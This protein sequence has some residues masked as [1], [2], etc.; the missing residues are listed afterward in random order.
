MFR[1]GFTPSTQ[2]VE[3]S[4]ANAIRYINIVPWY[5]CRIHRALGAKY[6]VSKISW[7][8]FT[9]CAIILIN[10]TDCRFPLAFL[11]AFHA[12]LR[13]VSCKPVV[14]LA[15][16]DMFTV[17]FRSRVTR[18]I[19]TFRSILVCSYG[20]TTIVFISA[21]K[22]RERICRASLTLCH[23]ISVKPCI[24][25]APVYGGCALRRKGINRTLL[26]FDS[27]IFARWNGT[28]VSPWA[29]AKGKTRRFIFTQLYCRTEA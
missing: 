15:V 16:I 26:A 21:T 13:A 5:R 29:Y 14:A 20:T 25:S 2:L 12:A 23:V 11:V 17:E 9:F 18:A 19:H 28:V 10:S 22:G 7:V 1:A 6:A 27:A 4:G 3:I 8:A 24:A